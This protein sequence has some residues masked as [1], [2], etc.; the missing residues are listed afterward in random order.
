MNSDRPERDKAPI[1]GRLSPNWREYQRE[2]IVWERERRDAPTPLL[3]GRDALTR[4]HRIQRLAWRCHDLSPKKLRGLPNAE[5]LATWDG[6][7]PGAEAVATLVPAKCP[8]IQ[9]GPGSDVLIAGDTTPV[10]I[11]FGSLFGFGL[12]VPGCLCSSEVPWP[13]PPFVAPVV[14][15]VHHRPCWSGSTPVRPVSTA[16]P[17]RTWSRCRRRRAGAVVSHVHHGSAAPR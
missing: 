5:L 4:R 9:G 11:P 15:A 12:P 7:H 10:V 6:A 13:T 3:A 1:G 17:R 8:S 14:L 2:M 16:A